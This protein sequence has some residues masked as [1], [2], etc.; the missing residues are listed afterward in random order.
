MGLKDADILELTDRY[1]FL[2][3]KYGELALELAPKLEK[4]GKYKKELQ[5]IT[6]E[7]VERGVNIKDPESLKN[8]LKEEIDK[9]GIDIDG[10]KTT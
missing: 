9:R 1:T 2:I 6:L 10:E 3:K 8:L 5:L 7:F 4:F